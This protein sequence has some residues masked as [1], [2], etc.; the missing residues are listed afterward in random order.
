[1]RKRAGDVEEGESQA[2]D[3]NETSKSLRARASRLAEGVV[4]H[5]ILPT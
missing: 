5:V 2:L 4:V 3:V 1:M